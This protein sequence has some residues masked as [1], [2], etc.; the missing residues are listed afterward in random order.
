[1]STIP[2]GAPAVA[3]LAGIQDAGERAANL[4]LQLLAFSRKQILTP[5]LL[6]LNAVVVDAERMLSRL[7][8]EDIEITTN[9]QPDLSQIRIDPGQLQQVIINLA[10]NARDAMPTGGR[11]SI[12][13]SEIDVSDSQATKFD[14]RPGPYVMLTIADTG[15]GMTPEVQGRIFEPFFTTK[16]QGKGTGLGLPTVFGIVKQSDGAI[17]VS[18][19][20][21]TGTSFRI[22]FPAAPEKLPVPTSVDPDPRLG[23][24]TVLIVEDEENV[25][26]IARVALEKHGYRVLDAAGGQEALRAVE[27]QPGSVDLVITDVVMPEMSGRELA[28]Q[29]RREHPDIRVLFMSGYTDDA[30]LRH[31]VSDESGDFLQKPF[32]PHDLVRKVRDLL[33][34]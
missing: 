4:T 9:L 26:E 8:G 22:L 11:L 20:V 10:V 18:S 19:Q 33:D 17:D 30:V 29:L 14:C 21:G 34:R 7:I 28:D 13:T 1:M 25:R 31:G 32:R 27:G 23:S 5:R 3:M 2:S 6:N 12:A 15:S 16:G 24:E